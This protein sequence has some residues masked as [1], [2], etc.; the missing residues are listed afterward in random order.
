MTLFEPEYDDDYFTPEKISIFSNNDYI[1][2]ESNSDRNRNLISDESVNKINPY[3]RDIIID[4][5]KS[6]T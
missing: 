4:L 6:D 5:Q 2:Y 3:L 1:E